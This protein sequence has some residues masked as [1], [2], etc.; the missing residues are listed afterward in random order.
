M[1]DKWESHLPVLTYE[2]EAPLSD[3]PIVAFSIAY[4][5]ELTGMLELFL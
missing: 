3:F 4:E 1:V 5:L 2:S